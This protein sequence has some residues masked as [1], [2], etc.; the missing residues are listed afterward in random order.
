MNYF[1][2]LRNFRVFVSIILITSFFCLPNQ[3]IFKVDKVI[4]QIFLFY[5]VI[6][7]FMLISDNFTKLIHLLYLDSG[8]DL[9][10]SLRTTGLTAG[11]DIS[12]LV[13]IFIVIVSNYF[14]SITQQKKYLYLMVASF[15]FTFFTSRGNIVYILILFL[16]FLYKKYFNFQIKNIFYASIIIILFSVTL[17]PYVKNIFVSS[18]SSE[19]ISNVDIDKSVIE[20]QY[21]KTD[22]LEMLKSFYILPSTTLGLIFGEANSIEV[23][24]GI[25]LTINN[26]GII[27]LLMLY[28]FYIFLYYYNRYK[29]K[30]SNLNYAIFIILV[31]TLISNIKNQYI[32]TRTAFEIYYF[33][34]IYSLRFY[35]YKNE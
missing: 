23:D 11:Y 15:V 1:D 27:G 28:I 33:F 6:V 22:I 29:I 34:I 25:I 31:L 3:S 19:Y 12:G 21:A 26:I 17:F 9:I 32:F 10:K 4:Y 5:I 7:F 16:I 14:F 8:K 2:L 30:N 13:L 18:V 35:V 24:S 20:N